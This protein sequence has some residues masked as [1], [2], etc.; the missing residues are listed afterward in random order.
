M[1]GGFE[2]TIAGVRFELELPSGVELVERDTVYAPFLVRESAADRRIAVALTLEASDDTS[3]LE[4]LFD[5]EE[6]WTAFADGDDVLLRL[7]TA[8]DA[9][10]E[11]AGGDSTGYLWLARLVG[12]RSGGGVERVIVACGDRLIESNGSVTRVTNPLHYPLD[13]LLLMFAL[14][15]LP[16]VLIHAAGLVC[17]RRGLFCAGV[18][19]AGKTTFMSLCSRRPD[20]V[21]LSDDRVIVRTIED[22]LR[23]YG[24][25]WAGEGRVASSRG[26]DLGAVAFLHQSERNA[27]RPIGAAEALAQLL[28]TV[29][30]LW[31]DR[32]RL[33]RAMSFC[34]EL[35]ARRPCFELH[36]RPEVEVLDL[37]DDLQI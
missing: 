29:S 8:G 4:V 2:L 16:G 12:G 15:A 3:N 11:T 21:G 13:Q 22:D 27:L 37:L 9:E 23:L 31:F 1:S 26:V 24:T 19:G 28:A 6:T 25:P 17:G 35:V 34:E 20:L 7:R 33:Q 14:P 32:D 5:T 36:F 18:S 30:I 10:G